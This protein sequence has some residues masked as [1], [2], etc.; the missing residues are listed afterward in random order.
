MN[1]YYKTL[2]YIVPNFAILLFCK[3]AKAT[4]MYERVNKFNVAAG[5][6]ATPA[7]VVITSIISYL[8]SFVGVLFII[9]IIY[10]GYMW[11]TARGNDE[12]V[13]KAKKLIIR[14][15]IGILIVLSAY[16]ITY[17]V[18]KVVLGSTG[19]ATSS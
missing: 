16:V 3:T 2:S 9:L 12:Q 14:A 19:I 5:L 1:K 15:T 18:L 11:M 10:G 8:L 4:E 6:T 13:E 17:F 7:S